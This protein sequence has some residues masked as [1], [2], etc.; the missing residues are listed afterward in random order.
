MSDLKAMQRNP[1]I[2]AKRLR[3]EGF[4][5]GCVYGKNFNPSLLIQV[6]EK[7]VHSFLKTNSAGSAVIISYGRK[8]I[9]TILKEV[10]MVPLS[11]KVEHLTFQELIKGEKVIGTVKLTLLNKDHVE[12]ATKHLIYDVQYKA[13]SEY[14]IEEVLLDMEGKKV[15]DQITLADIP[16]LNTE[17]I[18]L[19]SPLDS[20]VAEVKEIFVSEE[21]SDEEVENEDVIQPVVI[22]S[23]EKE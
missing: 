5:P 2:K 3:R 14:L 15:G 10:S 22:G 20:L 7:D 23:E 9:H 17:H 12:G 18:E 8:K 11:P 6:P 4:V 21:I 13:T 1:E 16:E 19:L